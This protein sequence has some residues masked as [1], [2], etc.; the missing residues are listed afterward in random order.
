MET[1]NDDHDG[2]VSMS[3]WVRNDSLFDLFLE[4]TPIDNDSISIIFEFLE[5]SFKRK[6]IQKDDQNRLYLAGQVFRTPAF[7]KMFEYPFSYFDQ[8][9]VKVVPPGATL[10]GPTPKS[11]QNE[12]PRCIT[13]VYYFVQGWNDGL[14]WQI[15][16]QLVDCC[17]Y[18]VYSY[19]HAWCDYTGFDCQCGMNLYLANSLEEVVLFGMNEFSRGEYRKM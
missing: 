9:T 10:K 15:L 11:I 3:N 1:E 16:A 4:F 8:T 5:I 2:I 12:F 18:V 13:K 17:G 7:Q 6:V 14:A 19:F